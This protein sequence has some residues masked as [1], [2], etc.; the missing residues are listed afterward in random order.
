MIFSEYII[1]VFY[2]LGMFVFDG[3]CKMFDVSVD[4]YVRGEVR[5][6]FV[7]EVVDVSEVVNVMNVL[8]VGVVVN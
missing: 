7:F 4:G 2:F 3:R 6:V 1:G 8:L 5:G